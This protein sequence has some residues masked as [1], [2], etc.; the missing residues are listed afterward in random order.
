MQFWEKKMEVEGEGGL[1]ELTTPARNLNHI[2]CTH[3][4]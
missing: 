1:P 2:L 3:G 4:L